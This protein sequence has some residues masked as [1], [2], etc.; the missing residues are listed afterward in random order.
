MPLRSS[1]DLALN[2][3]K[4]GC[5]LGECGACSVILDGMAVRSCVTAMR[6]AEKKQVTTL[7][8][9]AGDG[10]TASPPAGLH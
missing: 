2:G 9:L 1:N 3:P 6:D 4:F 7:E 10:R 5:G 8:G